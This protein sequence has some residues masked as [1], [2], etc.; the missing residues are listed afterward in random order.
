MWQR[1]TISWLFVGSLHTLRLQPIVLYLIQ[2]CQIFNKVM[3]PTTGEKYP[4][5]AHFLFVLMAYIQNKSNSHDDSYC[6]TGFVHCSRCEQ[7][8]TT[9][10]NIDCDRVNDADADVGVIGH[11]VVCLKRVDEDG[12]RTIKPN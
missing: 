5:V 11:L 1:Q 10:T 8:N 2:G 12:I 7:T 6:L 3:V 9:L 4:K